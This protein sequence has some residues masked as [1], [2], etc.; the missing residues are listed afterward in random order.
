M[1]KEMSKAQDFVD[2]QAAN[3]QPG[4]IIRMVKILEKVPY[5]EENWTKVFIRYKDAWAKK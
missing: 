2:K 4:E 5:S 1:G 3:L